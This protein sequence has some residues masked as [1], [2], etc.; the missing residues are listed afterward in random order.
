GPAAL[1][2]RLVAVMC[3]AHALAG[4]AAG[5]AAPSAQ[6]PGIT[7]APSRALL[8]APAKPGCT[9]YETGLGDTVSDAP[10]TA[11]QKLD[12]ERLGARRAEMQVRARLR[13]L[14][15]AVAAG[16]P[17]VP[18]LRCGLFCGLCEAPAAGR[19]AAD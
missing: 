2:S 11:R 9:F 17:P 10:E 19:P 13:R 16:T 8:A 7:P 15:A 5:F 12:Y 1:P 4:C 3:L 6:R 14:Q 18:R